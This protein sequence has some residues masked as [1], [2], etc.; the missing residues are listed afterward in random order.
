[1]YVDDFLTRTLTHTVGC[2]T[3]SLTASRRNH[4]GLAFS[5]HSLDGA[6][7]REEAIA[8]PFQ[9]EVLRPAFIG[10]MTA[11][12]PGVFTYSH[13]SECHGAI[14]SVPVLHHWGQG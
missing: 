9:P 13:N 14:R 5:L 1:M 7:V 2:R 6:R 11:Q 12:P 8:F 3:N 4:A 10:L